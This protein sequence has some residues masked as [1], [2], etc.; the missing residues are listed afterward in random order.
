MFSQLLCPSHT[1]TGVSVTGCASSSGF[2]VFYIVVSGDY[3]R[4]TAFQGNVFIILFL[5]KEL[6]ASV[7]SLTLSN[8]PLFIRDEVLKCETF[9]S[10]AKQENTTWQ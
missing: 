6:H 4:E 1:L 3:C 7:F 8:V 9:S 2:S 5:V 10:Q